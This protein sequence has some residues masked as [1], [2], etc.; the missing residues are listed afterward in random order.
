MLTTINDAIWKELDELPS[1]E[2]TVRKPAI[3]SLRR[4]LQTE[5][6]ERL[7]DLAGERDGAA[8]MK[9][10]ANLSV[11]MLKKVKDKLET[12]SKQE[13][14]D[15]YSQAHLEDALQRVTKWLDSQYVYNTNETGN[16]G[17]FPF[18]FFGKEGANQK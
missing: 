12:A 3:S 14:L 8:A 11:L 10:I 6:I 5:S 16:S 7:F 9:P 4:N 15:D 13:N 1:G 18:F 2:F 17:G